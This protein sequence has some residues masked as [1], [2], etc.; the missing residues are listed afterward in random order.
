M[1]SWNWSSPLLLRLL[2]PVSLLQSSSS[3]SLLLLTS[4]EEKR[5]EEE[6]EEVKL[7][8]RLATRLGGKG[9][10]VGSGDWRL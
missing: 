8:T 1:S 5:G 3:C 9:G 2:R 6:E 7:A 4:E 10:L